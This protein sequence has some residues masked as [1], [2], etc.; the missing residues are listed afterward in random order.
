MEFASVPAWM[1][2]TSTLPVSTT[3][4]SKGRNTVRD[5]QLGAECVCTYI[6]SHSSAPALTAVCADAPSIRCI[7]STTVGT[8][9]T[10]EEAAHAYDAALIK[11]HGRD[12]CEA[13]GVLNFPSGSCAQAQ[14][15]AQNRDKKVFVS[16]SKA[17]VTKLAKLHVL[18]RDRAQ[19]IFGP[20]RSWHSI[21]SKWMRENPEG[22]RR[23][24][25]FCKKLHVG[26]HGS[27]EFCGA[28]CENRLARQLERALRANN[29]SDGDG[30]TDGEGRQRKQE[31]RERAVGRNDGNDAYDNDT[32]CCTLCNK[33]LRTE[34]ETCKQG[35]LVAS[36]S[37]RAVCVINSKSKAAT[38]ANVASAR[39]AFHLRC[40][41]K[42]LLEQADASRAA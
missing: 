22:R 31:K 9:A 16:W 12:V 10:A 6:E 38:G 42:W 33:L 26:Q 15:G 34:V 14:N 19:K 37:R 8:Y 20:S 23:F 29:G 3:Q 39:H 24:C 18:D 30:D 4:P 5:V 35:S 27:G 7:W 2:P 21:K 40:M 11:A 13:N 17:E 36:D 1:D 28:G 32:S 41:E 25:G